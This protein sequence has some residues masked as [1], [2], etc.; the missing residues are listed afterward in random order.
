MKLGLIAKIASAV[1]AVAGIVFIVATYGDK[2]VAFAKK[3]LGK[4]ECTCEECECEG[5]E[6]CCSECEGCE[7]VEEAETEEVETEE[8][9]EA[10]E[11]TV[12][13]EEKDFE[14]Q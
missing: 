6:E 1:V 7:L 2:I 11:E 4:C 13:A 14:N 10:A 8:T 9:T 3:L 5:C 12:T